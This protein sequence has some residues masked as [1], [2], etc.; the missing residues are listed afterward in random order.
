[1]AEAALDVHTDNP[2]EALR[3]YESVGFVTVAS[4]AWYRKPMA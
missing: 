4:F 3:L 1:M 2:N